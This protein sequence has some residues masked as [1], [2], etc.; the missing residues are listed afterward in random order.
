M[1]VWSDLYVSVLWGRCACECVGGLM[2]M[3]VCV[4]GICVSVLTQDSV[5]YDW[6]VFHHHSYARYNSKSHI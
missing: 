1:R 2:C 4:G 5:V 6:V 3:W